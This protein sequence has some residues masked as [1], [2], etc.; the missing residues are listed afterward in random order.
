MVAKTIAGLNSIDAAAAYGLRL[1]WGWARYRALYVAGPYRSVARFCR[2]SGPLTR[3]LRLWS[4]LS[5]GV[6]AIGAKV[7]ATAPSV[8]NFLS[9]SFGGV[10]ARTRDASGAIGRGLGAGLSGLSAKADV[11]TR[12]AGEALGPA[13]VAPHRRH[14]PMRLRPRSPNGSAKRGQAAGHY[15]RGGALRVQSLLARSKEA[16]AARARKRGILAAG[17]R[18]I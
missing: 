9:R 18:E 7:H 14:G 5:A 10:A 16:P 3:A 15:A 8:G 12:Q 11:L 2:R 6:A 4:L 17:G 13:L 1:V